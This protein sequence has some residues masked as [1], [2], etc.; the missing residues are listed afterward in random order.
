MHAVQ[1]LEPSPHGLTATDHWVLGTSWPTPAIPY[2]EKVRVL[3]QRVALLKA[4]SAASNVSASAPRH[5]FK[6]R[7]RNGRSFTPRRSTGSL[8]A[9]YWS[10]SPGLQTSKNLVLEPFLASWYVI[11]RG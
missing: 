3:R 7:W 10:N 9:G 5:R 4:E 6:S 1:Q 2:A 11:R 8:E